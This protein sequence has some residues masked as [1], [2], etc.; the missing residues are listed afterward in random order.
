M[1]GIRTEQLEA[2][3]EHAVIEFRDW[4]LQLP[5]GFV[6]WIVTPVAEILKARNVPFVIASAY[7]KPERLGGAALAGAP[8]VGKPTIELRLLAASNRLTNPELK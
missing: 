6:A 7:E 1:T 2:A 8:N 5:V 3:Q 4:L